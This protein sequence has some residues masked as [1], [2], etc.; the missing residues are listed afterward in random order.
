MSTAAIIVLYFPDEN[1]TILSNILCSSKL[2][3]VIIVDNTPDGSNFKNIHSN[4]IYLQ[5]K[6]NIGVAAALNIGMK[7]AHDLNIEQ[8][9]LFDQDSQ[10]EDQYINKMINAAESFFKLNYAILLPRLYDINLKRESRYLRLKKFKWQRVKS[11]NNTSIDVDY[12]ITSGSLILTQV[13]Y[14]QKGF[15]EKLFIDQID[16]EY[17]LRIRQAGYKIA[18][19]CSVM[20]KHQIGFRQQKKFLG[21]SIIATNHAP[22]RRYYNMRNKIIVSK[23][24]FFSYPIILLYNILLIIND[25][26]AITFIENN[27]VKKLYNLTKGILQGTFKS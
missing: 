6:K 5:L 1:A 16:F 14:E 20:L 15:L 4:C 11:C 26:L 3:K 10:I 19:L 13:W 25:V 8:V 7:E 17:C 27:K 2:D 21:I 22:I 9:F 18:V 24:Y 12:G 23:K